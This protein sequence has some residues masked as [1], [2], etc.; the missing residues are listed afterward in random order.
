MVFNRPK[1]I[2]DALRVLEQ[3]IFSSRR[4]SEKS[5]RRNLVKWYRK[6][7]PREQ[8]C[9]DEVLRRWL[10]SDEKILQRWAVSLSQALKLKREVLPEL[11]RLKI[12]L[13]KNK[14]EASRRYNAVERAIKVINKS[15]S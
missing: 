6:L 2:S 12:A 15:R 13:R 11:K 1:N 5:I 3:G 14:L 8:A 9:V 7:S 4:I 10:L